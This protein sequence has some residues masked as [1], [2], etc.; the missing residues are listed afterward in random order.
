MDKIKL[1]LFD[2][3]T[4]ILPGSIILISIDLIKNPRTN[5]SE[6]IFNSIKSYTLFQVV[7][8]LSLC[9]IVGFLNQYISYKVFK[10]LS[11]KI[12]KTRMQGKETSISKLEDKIVMIRHFSP[13]NFNVLN[14]YLALRGMCYGMFVASSFLFII[15]LIRAIQLNCLKELSIEL[16][17]IVIC[18]ILFLRRAITIHEWIDGTIKHATSKMNEFTK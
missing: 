4:Y 8:L 12:W 13:E 2:T 1:G 7:I 11:K 6:F 18:S 5:F 16:I 17:V 15:V 14:T 3:F 10:F 9:Y